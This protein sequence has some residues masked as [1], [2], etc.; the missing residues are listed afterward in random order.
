M[1]IKLINLK[2]YLFIIMA[3]VL[4]NICNAQD[5]SIPEIGKKESHKVKSTL[6]GKTYQLNISL[7]MYYSKKTT[8]SYPVLF[9]LDGG[10][11][12]PIADAARTAMDIGRSIDDVIIVGI[13]YQWEK[14][15]VPWMTGRWQD[16][17]PSEDRKS[18][19]SKNFLSM[20]NLSVGSL[21]SGS[22]PQFLQVLKKDIIP[23]IDKHYRTSNDRGISGHS[24]GGLFV[25]Y[26]LF[27]EPELFSR[28]GINSPSLWWNSK[29]IFQT[30]KSFAGHHKSLNAQVF[31]SVGAL[32]GRSMTPVMTEFADSIRKHNYQGLQLTTHV[33][34]G[35]THLSVVPAMVSRTISTL[36]KR[37][38]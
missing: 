2:R 37:K 9:L 8:T 33:F 15:M 30:E 31:M 25:A 29:E 5:E 18:D 3:M 26:C 6:N 17:T 23:F 27:S 16:Y 34:E 7:P 4:V 13:E 19:T 36:Y 38:K 14:S 20:F 22:A 10:Y 24:L 1:R 35:E 32:E 28:Y 11:S 12:F 21:H